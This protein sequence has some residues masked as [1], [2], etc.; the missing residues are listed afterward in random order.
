MYLHCYHAFKPTNN[1]IYYRLRLTRILQPN[2][3]CAAQCLALKMSTSVFALGE[4][5]EEVAGGG[6]RRPSV[7]PFFATENG[8]IAVFKM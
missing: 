4:R 5:R 6:V 1:D 2:R 8:E 7:R 3:A